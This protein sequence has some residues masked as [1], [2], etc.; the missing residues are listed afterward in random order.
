MS[1]GRI[2]CWYSRGEA[3]RQA[4]KLAIDLNESSGDPKELIICRIHIEDEYDESDDYDKQSEK[5]FGQPIQVLKDEKYNA[6]VDQV[7][8]MTRY[9][10]GPKGARCTTEL[11]KNVRKKFQTFN[12]IHVF[13]YDCNEA[14]R[15]DKLLDAEPDLQIW[16]PLIEWNLSKVDCFEIASA[17][18]LKRATMYELG[19]YNDNCIG[20]LKAGGAGY[21]NKIRVDFPKVFQKRANQEKLLNVALVKMSAN[22]FANK[23]PE[24]FAMMLMDMKKGSIKIDTKGSIRIPLRYLPPDAGNHKDLEL[25]PCGFFCELES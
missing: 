17:Y 13:G 21:W 2:I 12:D 25:P 6:S 7:I 20:C 19:Y 4:T 18:G 23:Y 24:Y 10:S 14:H 5:Y 22:V 15:I 9:M 8:F 3:S 1:D 11:K 16:T